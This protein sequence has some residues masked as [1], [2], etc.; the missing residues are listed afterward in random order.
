MSDAIRLAKRLAQELGCSR[1]QAEQ[2]IEGGWVSVDGVPVEEPAARVAPEQRVLLDPAASAE[3]VPPASMLLYKPEGVDLALAD[4]LAGL[5]A[6]QN[7]A[8]ADTSGMRSLRKHF[9]QLQLL[10][11]L[12]P[13]A[14][15][16]VVLSQDRRIVRRLTE[17]ER[18]I[19]QEILVDFEH[20]ISPAL[21]EK[22]QSEAAKRRVPAKISRQSERRLRFAVKGGIVSMIAEIC[23]AVGLPVSR[24]VRLRIGRV[25]LAGLTVGQW[26]YL[27][28]DEWF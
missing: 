22:I 18:R 20:E 13:E 12:P 19:E 2:Y 7:R 16:L 1:R 27:R 3:D 6:P 23:A 15:G 17:E 11:A 14:S 28:D 4:S 25:G 5:L 21:L 26:R 24:L 8:A 9:R 10:A